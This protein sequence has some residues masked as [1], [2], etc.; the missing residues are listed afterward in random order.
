MRLQDRGIA[1][2][3]SM[4]RDRIEEGKMCVSLGLCMLPPKSSTH[5]HGTVHLLC[6]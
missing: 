6:Q 4:A 1:I 5:G 3:M 2:K